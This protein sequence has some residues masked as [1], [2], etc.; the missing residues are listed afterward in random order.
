M[1]INTLGTATDSTGEPDVSTV[2]KM[3]DYRIQQARQNLETLCVLKAKAEAMQMLDYPTEFI[4]KL[5]W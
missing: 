5:G 4:R 1:T 2:G 3:M